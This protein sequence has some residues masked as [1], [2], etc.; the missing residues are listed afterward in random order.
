MTARVYS[1]TLTGLASCPAT[2][3]ATPATNFDVIGMSDAARAES[4]VIVRGALATVDGPPI[5]PSVVLVPNG[6]GP[7]DLA[8]AVAALANGGAIQGDTHALKTTLLLAGLG[9]SGSLR[10]VRGVLPMLRG[11]G[12]LGFT[13]AIVAYENEAEAADAGEREGVQ[14]LVASDLASVVAGLRGERGLPRAAANAPS[15]EDAPVEAFPMC[16]SP[17]ELRALEVAA[18]GSHSLAIVG[19]VGSGKVALARRLATLLPQLDDATAVEVTSLHSVAGIVQSPTGLIRSSPFR[20]PHHSVSEA[21]MVGGGKPV[22]PGEVSL[23]HGGVLFLDEWPE[24]SER[25]ASAITYAVFQSGES[26]L[27]RDGVTVRFPAR[28]IV[29]ASLNPCPC[30][31]PNGRCSC[32]RGDSMSPAF[33]SYRKRALGRLQPFDMR[34]AVKCSDDRTAVTRADHFAARA[35]VRAARAIADERSLA[36]ARRIASGGLPHAHPR[37]AKL[38]VSRTIADLDGSERVASAHIDEALSLTAEVL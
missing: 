26:A 8:I 36:E 17:R 37:L 33:A 3:E 25:V 7:R 12:K 6:Y 11:M 5:A 14:C 13:H 32:V 23:A 27:A 1:A 15:K 20:A 38:G 29:V 2:I 21:G 9:M 10:P 24:F 28:P 31:Q 35:R 30:G 19:P 18:A 16:A 34:L 22:R 4:R